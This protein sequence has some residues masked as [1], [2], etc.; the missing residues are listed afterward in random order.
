MLLALLADF[1][2]VEPPGVPQVTPLEGRFEAPPVEHWRTRLPER[3]ESATHTEL[4]RPAS[5]GASVFVGIASVNALVEL[6]RS[7]GEV[8]RRYTANA[9]FWAALADWMTSLR[10]SPISSAPS[11][12]AAVVSA[13]ALNLMR[14]G[15]FKLPMLPIYVDHSMKSAFGALGA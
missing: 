4:S 6:D 1:F 12:P 13:S 7:T 9:P 3:H 8:V 5:D 2:V 10:W 15:C 11:S 14:S